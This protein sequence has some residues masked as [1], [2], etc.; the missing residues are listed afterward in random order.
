MAT[1][2]RRFEPRKQPVQPRAAETRDRILTAATRIFS[3]HGYSAG[4]TNRIA[5]EA[6]VSVGSLYQYFPN[7]DA[8]LVAL[9]RRHATEGFATI[10]DVLADPRL[11]PP[12]LE[13][14]IAVFVDAAI[15]NHSGDPRLH[16]VLF[17]EAPRPPA[18]LAELHAGEELIVKAAAAL[19][20]AEPRVTTTDPELAARM[21]VTGIESYVHRF[22]ATRNPKVALDTFR[23]ELVALLVAYLT[24][25]TLTHQV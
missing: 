25:P 5:E 12:T 16:Q 8:I 4:T 11:L 21:V 23:D 18:V 17:E 3:R 22:V 1:P 15:A 2:T 6:G 10:V 19:L 7:K 20:A 13:A 24:R 9:V 14:R